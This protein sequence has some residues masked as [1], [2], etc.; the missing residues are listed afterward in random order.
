MITGCK[1]VL[2]QISSHNPEVGL[3]GLKFFAIKTKPKVKNRSGSS[4]AG[5]LIVSIKTS[6]YLNYY[7]CPDEWRKEEVK[8]ISHFT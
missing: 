2:C 7:F 8:N 3:V 1:L 6:L 5:S 4:Q